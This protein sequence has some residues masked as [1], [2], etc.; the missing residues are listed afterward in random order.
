VTIDIGYPPVSNKGMS[1]TAATIRTPAEH[2]V[3]RDAV[4]MFDGEAAL[5]VLAVELDGYSR[6]WV[7]WVE[8][9]TPESFPMGY[10]LHRVVEA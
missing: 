8:C 5:T 6:V 10:A 1:D 7:T 9:D 3:P 4:F 2:L